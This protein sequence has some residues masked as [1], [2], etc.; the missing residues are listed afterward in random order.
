M[1]ATTEQRSE[2][3]WHA[4]QDWYCLALLLCIVTLAWCAAYNRWSAE[5]WKIPVRY[6]GDVWAQMATAKAFAGDGVAPILPKYPGSLGAPFRANWNDHI[7]V[8]EAVFSIHGLCVRIFG[9][10]LGSNIA[11]LGAHLLAAAGFYLT[12]RA[13]GG[14]RSFSLAFGVLFAMSYYALKRNLEHLVL[15]YYW[16]VPLG[17]LVVWWCLEQNSS[18]WTSRRVLIAAAIAVVHGVQSP[19]YTYMFLQFLG[20]ASLVALVRRWP[21]RQVAAPLL[22]GAIAVASFAAM[23]I[24]TFVHYLSN[25]PN[26]LVTVRYYGGVE[27]YALKPLELFL[28]L[29]HSL[30]ALQTWTTK[31]YFSQ[32]LF[33][34]EP[35]SPYLGIIAIAGL[36]WLGWLVFK[37]VAQSDLAAVPRH[38]WFVLWVVLYSIVGGINGVVGVFGM[39]LFRGTNR[40]SIVI[41]ALALLFLAVE[42]TRRLRHWR[43]FSVSG[44]ALIVMLV[45]LWDQVKATSPPEIA[46]VAQTV[47]SDHKFVD[48]LETKLPR[49]SAVFQLPVSDYPEVDAVNDMKD[50]EHFR[51][52]LYSKTLRFS[53]GSDKGRTRERWQ[54]EAE[55]L[56][57]PGLIPLLERY[58]FSAVLLNKKA[59]V[60]RAT[61]LVQAFRTAGR[62]NI[63]AESRDFIAIEVKA[64][65]QPILP[66]EFDSHWFPLEAGPHENWRW[67]DGDATIILHNN[68]SSAR[69]VQIKFALVV[70][71]SQQVAIVAPSGQLYAASLA[72]GDPPHPVQLAFSIPPGS[73]ALRFDTDRS[74]Q[75][76]G[77][78]DPRKLAFS[79]RNFTIEK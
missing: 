29:N 1:V 62:G 44:L 14:N 46:T 77:N 30:Q 32:A 71:H 2:K 72:P 55:Q 79:V 52:Y 37:R 69:Q 33:L 70:S 18:P 28:P 39:V 4:P 13:L 54:R 65:R 56:G 67:S 15:T 61:S 19:Y 25:G 5:A 40:F 10:I 24:D 34:G 63:L 47:V 50:Y 31:N 36:A 12:S 9:L 59:Y 27:R 58:G 26:A 6:Q 53:Y 22:I 57:P 38:F 75:L 17:I 48:E 35:A 74:G 60:D 8:E 49:G 73:T 11:V 64:A 78:D 7:T 3:G 66:P 68:E 42:L 20:I 21:L 51:P 41:L 43:V 16:H 23:N 76:P 45:G